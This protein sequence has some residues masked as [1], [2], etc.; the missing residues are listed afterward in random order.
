M[1]LFKMICVNLILIFSLSSSSFCMR[2]DAKKKEYSKAKIKCGKEIKIITNDG[3]K[4]SGRLIKF[5]GDSL[6]LSK[7]NSFAFSDVE[8]IYRVRRNGLAMG[9][10]GT[11]AGALG[12]AA[13]GGNNYQPNPNAWMDF[14]G[15]DAAI[16][17]AVIGGLIGCMAGVLIGQSM[18]SY[19][20]VKLEVVPMCLNQPGEK[21]PIGLRFAVNF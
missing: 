8:S 21:N 2:G 4:Q 12:G 20:K 1:K 9:V 16:N 17:G 15:I 6:T 18:K 13:I 7:G 11:I 14:G 10:I 5:D 19:K 3:F